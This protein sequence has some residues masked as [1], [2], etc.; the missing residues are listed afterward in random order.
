MFELVLVP[1]FGLNW[2]LQFFGPNLPKRVALFSQNRHT[3]EF[4]IFELVFVSN[5]TLNKQLWVFEPDLPK[6]DIYGQKQKNW[7]SSLNSAYSN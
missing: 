6:K 5:F 1:T 7:T 2:Q 4:Y 3:I